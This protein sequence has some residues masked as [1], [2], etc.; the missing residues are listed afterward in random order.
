[1]CKL[2]LVTHKLNNSEGFILLISCIFY[3]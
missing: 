1:M 2:V 3:N